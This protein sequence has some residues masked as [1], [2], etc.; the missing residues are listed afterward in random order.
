MCLIFALIFFFIPW[1]VAYLCCWLI[2]LQ[3]CASDVPGLVSQSTVA[4]P[5]LTR[6]E[7]ASRGAEGSESVT[8]PQDRYSKSNSNHKAHLLLL[9]TW[10]LPLAA[11]VLVVW[12]R[13]LV[14]AGLTTPFDGDHFFFN[15]APFIILV[16]FASWTSSPLLSRNRSV[17]LYNL[18]ERLR[19]MV[20]IVAKSTSQ[21]D[22]HFVWLL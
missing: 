10:L 17:I 15:V 7:S 11:P 8:A 12:V 19:L 21:Q 14:T 5:L 6:D 2:H 13:T 3:S 22:G 16:D 18:R 20:L 1:Q 4:V 9:M